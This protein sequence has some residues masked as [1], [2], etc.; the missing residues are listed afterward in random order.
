MEQVR[1]RLWGQYSLVK[2]LKTGGV[3]QGQ[4]RCAGLVVTERVQLPTPEFSGSQNGCSTDAGGLP[5]ISKY[6]GN[7]VWAPA[8][9]P[10]AS[11]DLEQALPGDFGLSHVVDVKVL[12]TQVPP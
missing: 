3:V 4:Q 5:W 6:S 2:D 11:C 12:S 1:P 9:R 8:I 10:L 7:V